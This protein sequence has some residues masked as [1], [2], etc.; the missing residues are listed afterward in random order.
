MASHLPRGLQRGA[1]TRRGPQWL[2]WAY[3]TD[4]QILH[5]S[6][7]S[8]LFISYQIPS[9][10]TAGRHRTGCSGQRV[11]KR[12]LPVSGDGENGVLWQG[13]G[14]TWGG[15]SHPRVTLS[16]VG[17]VGGMP[18]CVRCGMG[19]SSC[20]RVATQCGEPLGCVMHGAWEAGLWP[21][22]GSPCWGWG[23][24]RIPEVC[25]LPLEPRGGAGGVAEHQGAPPML[26]GPWRQSWGWQDGGNCSVDLWIAF[27]RVS[28]S[29]FILNSFFLQIE[30]HPFSI[31]MFYFMS[32]FC[33]FFF[34]T[35][36]AVHAAICV[37]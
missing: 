3:R 31:S 17:G 12:E 26:Q 10:V 5:I 7:L 13:V 14:C 8:F 22:D 20:R 24:G 16:R 34:L 9:I 35:T 33:L 11:G 4:R 1:P 27:F 15:V 21:R 32:L 18:A 36:R 23:P 6:S 28:F 37:R 29:I 30:I 19:E 25:L 2:S